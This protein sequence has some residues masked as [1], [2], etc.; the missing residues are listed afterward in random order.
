MAEYN[1]LTK[2]LLSEGYTAE[3]FPKD[4][5]HIAHGCYSRNGNPLDNIYG[6]FEYNRIYCE[7]FIYK[8]GCGMYVKWKNV[9]SII[10]ELIIP[11]RSLSILHGSLNY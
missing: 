10:T 5:V 11:G 6:G 3:N 9:L 1:K 7:S 8:T 2:N 4:K